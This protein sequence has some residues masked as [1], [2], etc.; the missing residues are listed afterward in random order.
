RLRHDPHRDGPG[1][2]QQPQDAHA[3]GDERE[4]QQGGLM[5]LLTV[6]ND[7]CAAVGVH[8]TTSVV[9][10]I[11][12]NRTMFEMLAL[13]NEMAARI[14]T[15]M[16]DWTMLR[17]QATFAGDGIAEAFNLP[18]DYSRMLTNS[19]VWRSTSTLQPM[20]F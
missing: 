10:S 6:V 20:R 7:V 19:H 5:T 11:N 16:R 17:K 9:A 18:A 13:A 2:Q 3:H 12:A 14:A 8:Q 4:A 1:G 15:D